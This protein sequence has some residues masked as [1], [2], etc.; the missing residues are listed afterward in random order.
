MRGL[1]PIPLPTRRRIPI[2]VHGRIERV[3]PKGASLV[4]TEAMYLVVIALVAFIVTNPFDLGFRHVGLTKH[5]GLVLTIPLLVVHLLGRVLVL[6]GWQ[7]NALPRIFEMTWPWLMLALIITLGSVYAERV[8]GIHSNFLSFGVNVPFVFLSAAV[9]ALSAAPGRILRVYFA[10]WVVAAATMALLVVVEFGR[11]RVYHEEIFLIVPMAIF[12]AV[13]DRRGWWR[14]PLALAFLSIAVLSR[15]NTSHL[16]GLVTIVYF[17]LLVWLPQRSASTR[18]SLQGPLKVYALIT[19]L[20]VGIGAVSYVLVNRD[21]YLPS[22][23][24]EYRLHTYREAVARFIESPLW[25]TGFTDSASVRFRKFTVASSTQVLPVHSDI[26]D[27]LAH[28]G[29]IA[30]LLWAYGL[31]KAAGRSWKNLLRPALLSDEWAPFAHTLALSS[32]CAVVVYAFNPVLTAIPALSYLLWTNLGL[33]IGLSV[34]REL[35]A[36]APE[37]V[38]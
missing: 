18:G 4:W 11:A 31:L 7:R 15:K 12:F 34:C 20:A 32:I 6:P 2:V 3:R 36:E 1:I 14:W 28:G 17:G 5:I 24:P 23:N 29:A 21:Q 26:L 30:F 8:N 13:W 38:R 33:L 9:I 16:M 37:A 19:M 22:G 27:I 10:I 35:R 25:G